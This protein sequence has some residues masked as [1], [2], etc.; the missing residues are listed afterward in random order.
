MI[1]IAYA[2]PGGAAQGGGDQSAWMTIL[3][4][5]LIFGVFYLLLIRPQ[6]QKAKE[7]KAMLDNLKKGDS[8]ITQG[9][10]YGK[11]V[12]ITDDTAIVEVADKVRLKVS[13]AAIGGIVT[14][15]S[16]DEKDKDKSTS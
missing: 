5:L 6:Q 15:G 14:I 12:S 1:D 8:I 10:I 7:H 11:I 2:M 4:M 13:R 16:G 3:P 9:G